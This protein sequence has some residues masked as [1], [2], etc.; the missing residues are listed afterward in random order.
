MRGQ[1]WPKGNGPESVGI[2]TSSPAPTTSAPLCRMHKPYGSRTGEF[3]DQ[4][5]RRSG[6]LSKWG[7]D[8]SDEYVV[9]RPYQLILA[10][11]WMAK[12]IYQFEL[13]RARGK[14]AELCG[15]AADQSP[16]PKINPMSIVARRGWQLANLAITAHSQ[17]QL[18]HD[19]GT[20]SSV[21]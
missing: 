18:N 17:V 7:T 8:E 21:S 12:R 9:T 13:P 3:G 16:V 15:V 4:S 10:V 20:R 11:G 1:A 14:I 5:Q 6:Y 2:S 19:S